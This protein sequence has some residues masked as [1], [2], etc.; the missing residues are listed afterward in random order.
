M[1]RKVI[2]LIKKEL[3]DILRDRKTLIIM[4]LVPVLLYPLLIIGMTLGIG[5]F[6]QEEAET[7]LAVSY[8]E[9]QAELV[10][11]LEQLYR[12]QEEDFWA[13]LEFVSAREEQGDIS[14]RAEK[15]QD[16]REHVLI[17][18]TSS[19]SDSADAKDAVEELLGQYR[20]ELL[21]ENLKREGLDE[22][23]LEPILYEVQDEAT[24][25]E[26]F[27]I[28]FGSSMGG[29]IALMLII[30][31][32]LGAVYPAIDAT[33]GEKER[34]TLETLLTLPVTNFQMILSK[35]ISVAL[36]ATVT[37]ILS[38]L[39]LGGSVL[40][41]IYGLSDSTGIEGIS[42]TGL[43]SAIPI[44]LL[45]VLVMAL[46]ASALC[47]CFCT[48]AKSFKEANN[49]VTPVLLIVMF[50]A[51]VGMIP[52]IEFNYRMAMIP[53]VNVSLLVRQMIMQQLDVSLAILVIGTNLCYSTLIV[54][55]LAKLYNS[56]DILF[57][58]GF[59]RFRLFTK[60]SE[61]KR[62]TVPDIGDMVVCFVV[63]LLLVLYAGSAA[64]VHFGIWGTAVNELIMLAVPLAVVWY[65]KSD[66]RTLFS[67][68]RPKLR[69]I[70]GSVLLYA[71]VYCLMLAV[72]AVLMRLFPG[73]SENL[74][75]T[76]SVITEQPLSVQLFVIAFMPA[77]CEEV[78]FRGF[79]FGSLREQFHRSLQNTAYGM[80]LRRDHSLGL[81]ILISALVFGAFHMS[82]VKLLPTAMLG[83]AFAYIV[84]R[85]GSIYVT[86]L[87]HFFNNTFSVAAMK[88]PEATARLL[89]ILAK[90][91]LSA[92][93]TGLLLGVGAVLFAVGLR[94]MRIGRR[95]GKA[96]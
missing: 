72:S 13:T 56:E 27:G 30:T 11:E 90:E 25:A 52:D 73:S 53:I 81:A 20:Q 5:M 14:L 37:A 68:N 28:D 60:R 16:G 89:P 48:F 4:V 92:T 42:F 15:D 91:E 85:T 54:W 50:A 96:K 40:F 86:V 74:T 32:M 21:V 70:P 64:T 62:N 23:F 31:I 80:K 55:I 7:V 94:L 36:I 87:L 33:A 43:L 51:M 38:V 19:D 29:C 71:G 69:R 66:V 57:G 18:Y 75:E 78:L 26:S 79:L 6:L 8:E 47:M 22:S 84:S 17:V 82:L 61:I 83:A 12:E 63:L 24:E 67:L 65:V 45:T 76:F 93:E 46:L 58:E 95:S 77:V 10:E 1:L 2:V 35:Y 34:G 49:Y 41:M 3:L 88:Y 39:S 59:R 9:E 44:L